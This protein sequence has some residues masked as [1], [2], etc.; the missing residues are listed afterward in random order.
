[1]RNLLICLKKTSF[2]WSAKLE[3]HNHRQSAAEDSTMI[4]PPNH[5][6]KRW[7]SRLAHKAVCL[8]V[9]LDRWP[10]EQHLLILSAHKW[11]F[12][13]SLTWEMNMDFLD[14]GSF[15]F[16]FFFFAFHFSFLFFLYLYFLTY[17]CT[18]WLVVFSFFAYYLNIFYAVSIWSILKWNIL[19]LRKK[20]RK[21]SES[22]EIL[23]VFWALAD[24]LQ[25]FNGSKWVFSEPVP[26]LS[27]L[28][29]FIRLNVLEKKHSFKYCQE[30]R[31]QI[32]ANEYLGWW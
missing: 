13:L 8:C 16:F 18:V 30:S 29:I 15:H 23:L 2:Y 31:G 32:E 25:Q 3:G 12:K 4:A 10:S 9:C 22:A 21:E 5:Q 14:E 26:I 20:Y 7:I 6:T 24:G 28:F 27:W 11:I 1:M 17:S 19:S